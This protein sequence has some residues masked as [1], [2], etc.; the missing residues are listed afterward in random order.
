MADDGPAPSHGRPPGL[1][2]TEPELPED[3]PMTIWEHIGELRGRLVKVLIGMIPGVIVAWILREQLLEFLIQPM[4]EAWLKLGLGEPTIH[5][6]NP[7]DPFVAYLKIAIVVGL[8]LSSPWAFWQLWG[9]IAPG[10][11]DKEKRYAIPFVL[12]STLFFLGGAFFGYAVVFPL[13]F[14]TFLSMSGMLPA[15][16]VNVQ[17]TIM[18][19]EYLTFTTRMLFAFGVVFEIPVIVSFLA[20]AGLVNWKQLLDFGRWWILVAAVL[21]ALLTPPDVGSQMLMLIPLIV[22]YFL[23]VGLAYFIGPKVEDD[24]EA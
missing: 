5:F 23:S 2:E 19:N 7:I 13:G 4:T 10:L 17:P 24:A 18:I 8:M 15:E 14:Q 20:M 21:A 11:Y 22:L 9:F 1:P 12:A 6:A 16:T 3:V